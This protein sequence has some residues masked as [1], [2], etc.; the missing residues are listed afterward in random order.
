MADPEIAQTLTHIHRTLELVAFLLGVLVAQ[1]G[2]S[3]G[4]VIG[5]GA[6]LLLTLNAF[7]RGTVANR[8]R[9]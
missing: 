6:A 1:N 7:R 3:L 8:N 9:A 4:I 2:G 5:G